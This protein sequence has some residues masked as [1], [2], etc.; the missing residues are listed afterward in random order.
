MDSFVVLKKPFRSYFVDIGQGW[1]RNSNKIRT[2]EMS[3]SEEDVHS[4]GNSRHPLVLVHGFGAG[5]GTWI[6]NLDYLASTINRKIYAFDM[7]GF[8]RSSRAPFNLSGDVEN[9]FIDSIERWREKQG[10]EKF[11]LLGHSF[12]GY[13]SASYALKYPERIAHVILADPWGFQDRQVAHSRGTY[14]FPLWV[15]A[16]NSI[17]Q[18][19][20]PLAVV[21]VTGPY[22]PRLVHKFRGDLKEK[23]RPKLGEDCYKFLNYLYH[24]NAQTATGESAF[25]A[26]A[27]PYGWPKNPM[28]HRIVTLD[29]SIS[30]TFI[31]GSRSWIE[32]TPGEFLY[33]CLTA[34]RVTLHVIQGSGH[35]VYADKYNEF[36]ELVR[37]ACSKIK[38]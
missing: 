2:L 26:L 9:Q 32:R 7:I 36:N 12:G 15:R 22:G 34:S 29:P 35:H 14:K 33:E 18:A 5:I 4:E 11:I 31:Y 37:D 21:R 8:A 25:K 28:I 1:G 16:V 13:L 10:I 27:L 17:F 30:V 6:L 19:F 38:N 20:N 23:F 24:C 3:S